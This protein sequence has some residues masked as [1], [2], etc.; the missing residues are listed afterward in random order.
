M[1]DDI[2]GV[3]EQGAKHQQ[4]SDTDNLAKL[5]NLVKEQMAIEDEIARV[6]AELDGFNKQLRRIQTELLP[7]TFQTLGLEKL[8]LDDGSTVICKTEYACSI[9]LEK[10]GEAFTWF[11]EQGLDDLI[12]NEIKTSFGRGEENDAQAL[13]QELQKRGVNFTQK[14]YVHP[15]TLKSLVTKRMTEGLPISAAIT[16]HP[17]TKA[18]IKR[19]KT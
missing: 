10:Q 9:P 1:T 19:P 4:E 3:F 14:K 11:K 2:A 13:A 12:K 17:I 6:T 15:Q 7:E 5:S 8:Q 18:K 16:A